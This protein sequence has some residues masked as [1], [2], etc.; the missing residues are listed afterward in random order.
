MTV[1]IAVVTINLFIWAAL[2]CAARWQRGSDQVPAGGSDTAVGTVPSR[3]VVV[4]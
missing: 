4:K 1:L 2:V 3:R